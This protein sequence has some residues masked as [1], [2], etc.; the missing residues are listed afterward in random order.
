MRYLFAFTCLILAIAAA[1]VAAQLPDSPTGR[2]G[3][4]VIQ[5]FKDG[6][7]SVTADFIQEKFSEEFLAATSLAERLAW[8]SQAVERIGPLE[9]RGVE[10]TDQFEA[11]ISGLSTKT[12]SKVKIQYEVADSPP[13]PI[14]LLEIDEGTGA[15]PRQLTQAE[16]IE[17]ATAYLDGLSTDDFS[18][19]VL[20]AKGDEVLLEKA[21]GLASRCCSHLAPASAIPTGATWS[22]GRS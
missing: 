17:E 18:G 1:P 20:V 7:D 11:L 4:A 3:N 14:V 21:T 19:T 16:M 10:K 9:L 2:G 13:H 12:G 5:M 15:P 22:S 8:L 6:P